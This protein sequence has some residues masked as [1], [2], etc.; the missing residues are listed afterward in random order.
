M[1]NR[2]LSL[3][4]VA[5]FAGGVAL[6]PSVAAAQSA[7]QHGVSRPK[8]KSRKTAKRRPSLRAR[9]IHRAFVASASLK[10]MAK[11]LVADR[12]PAAY[13][14]VE[15]YARRHAG[16]DA[17]ALA[18]LAVGYSRVLDK[19]YTKAVP[20]LKRAQA[21]A[22]ELSDYVTYYLG[23]AYL[24]MGDN[25]AAAAA[26][27]T[28]D[29]DYPDSVFQRDAA[30]LYARALSAE[31]QPNQAIAVLEAHRQPVRSD[32]ELALGRA[33]IAAGDTPHAVEVLRRVYAL[34]PLSADADDAANSLKTVSFTATYEERKQRAASLLRGRRWVDAARE[35]RDLL[36]DAPAA[37]RPTLQVALGE[38]LHHN[39]R[40]R[41]AREVLE[42]IAGATGDVEAERLNELV[43]IARSA[44]DLDRV[45]AL[46]GQM[47]Q[48]T[49]ASAWLAA[50]LMS[51]GNMQLLRKDLDRA[52]DAY[53]EID[54]HFP[55]SPRAAYAHWKAT[56]LSLR[57]NRREQGKQDLEDQIARYPSSPEVPAA[58]YWRARMAEQDR[59]VARCRAFYRKL[60][61]RFPNYYYA[62]LARARLPQ[63]GEDGAGQSAQASAAGKDTHSSS[64]GGGAGG[65]LP[66]DPVLQKIPPA[67]LPSA[68]LSDDPP[69][70]DVRMERAQLLENGGLT[71]LAVRELQAA[72]APGQ[73]SG[74]ALV[75]IAKLYQDAG[76]YDMALEAIKR[77]LPEYFAF[78]IT[79]LPRSY[80]EALFPRPFWND[81]QRYARANHLDPFLVA[82]LIR[83][84]SEFN[85]GAVSHANAVGLMQLLPGTGRKVARE[86]RVRRFSTQKLLN[87]ATNL[88]LGTRYFRSMVDQYNGTVEYALAAYNAG[89]DR[90]QGWLSEG[91][92]PSAEEFVESIPFTETRE[93]V[94]AI[95]RNASLYRRLYAA[96]A[97]GKSV[98]AE[99]AQA[100]RD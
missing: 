88:Q 62:D 26:L 98:P 28:F 91:N 82:A 21:H 24:G 60:I 86:L 94:Q 95:L 7:A 8:K 54:Q 57:Q 74:W 2:F 11:Q 81:L 22:G 13:R 33:Y 32:V 51:L 76:R 30:V 42:S 3:I 9:K 35:Y 49:P 67:N 16:D 89:S 18:W 31:N 27:R 52:I 56:W 78:D 40:D 97:A 85:P 47:R 45:Q 38:A 84:E 23:S 63:L 64:D 53:R 72:A 6:C 12:T 90:V 87:P 75:Q 34:M 20:A 29:A 43:E 48:A 58:L 80:W 1:K 44:D 79:A 14:G 59:D 66:A 65:D 61:D 19:D 100:E 71:S 39:G 77:A 41:D 17:G 15:A 25:Q 73:K 5:G 93:Y 83:Q 36:A 37:D 46:V 99:T 50:A 68:L 92:F 70:D 10:P 4:L 55:Q 96:S 69:D